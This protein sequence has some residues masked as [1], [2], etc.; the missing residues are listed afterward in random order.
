MASEEGMGHVYAHWPILFDA[1]G[2]AAVQGDYLY[3]DYA[4][5]GN[6]NGMFGI[7]RV[8]T[9]PTVAPPPDEE[10]PPQMCEW[11]PE[12]LASDPLC[13]KPCKGKKCSN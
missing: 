13:V 5:N 12:L 10:P 1:G 3:R 8:T 7:L 4:P 6:R 11:Y 9:E 2:T